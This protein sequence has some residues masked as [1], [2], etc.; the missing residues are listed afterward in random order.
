[1]CGI[2]G[3][4]N[5]AF[6]ENLLD[7]LE[8]RG[9][10]DSGLT[11]LKVGAHN[12]ILGHR[13]LSIVDT[14][15][16]GHQPMQ[17][18]CGRYF[19]SYNGE[20]YNHLDLRDQFTNI[21]L[22]GHSDT[23]TILNYIAL[24]GIEAVR[25][26]NGI[27]A[28]GFVDTA[29]GKLY[30]VRDPFGVKPL[31]YC[32]QNGSFVFSSEIK[33]IQKLIND[34]LDSTN[35]SELLCLRYL[36]SPDTLFKN[37]KKV[38]PGHILE[39]NLFDKNLPSQQRPFFEPPTSS[40]EI[41][42]PQAVEQYGKLFERAVERQLMSDVEIGILLSG[43]I[44]SALVA[45][46]AQ[47]HTAYKMKA[48][49]VGFTEQDDT[50][51]ISDAKDTAS[52]IGLDYYKT[53]LSFGNFLDVMEKCIRIVEEPL[54]TTSVVPMY[55][56][57][58][59]AGSKVKVI[60]TGQ[61]ADEPLG[62]YGRYQGELYRDCLPSAL[63]RV[64]HSLARI[65]GTKNEQLLRGL[66]CLGEKSDLDRF[67]KVYSVFSDEEILA[68]TGQNEH[69]SRKKISY[70]YYLLQCQRKK[71]S[72]ERMMSLDIRMNLADDLL[73][74][75]DKIT[76][77][78]SLECRVP[79]LDMELVRFVES[80]PYQYRVKIRQSKIIH[81]R[82]ANKVLPNSIINR[83]KKGFLS[84]TKTWFKNDGFLRD[85]LLEPNSKFSSFFDLKKVDEILIEHKK[86]YGR[87]RHIFLLL[88]LFYWMKEYL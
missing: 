34:S 6:D 47:K 49:T 19:I 64:G 25:Q 35:L 22:N 38:R 27:F 5:L 67:L 26:F 75:T 70:F 65:F 84:P 37:V 36:P 50:D 87:E 2:L 72:V 11:H 13:R 9:P 7:M 24:R 48:F 8:H 44:D 77:H 33:P 86:G 59:L 81:K 30:L 10:D 74:Y 58:E 69:D 4:V 31:Y 41:P 29:K 45:S 32:K 76:M 61:G 73:L 12:L 3:T 39:V 62:G 55:C 51:E 88:N 23:E 21:K 46:Y 85:I 18:A 56:L 43:G 66:N 79:M 52:V 15:P 83:K 14:S 71:H 78:H 54:A 40:I 28:F 20:I 80:L 60:L 42:F 63:F 57:S 1:M 16:A 53:R 68:L 17:T 82:F